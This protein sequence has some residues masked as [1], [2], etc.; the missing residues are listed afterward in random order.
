MFTKLSS[1][2]LRSRGWTVE[3]S[4]SK[5]L[6]KKLYVVV[7]HTH[8]KDFFLGLLL[9]SSENF[10]AGF[11][12]KKALFRFP[13]GGI[14]RALGGIPIDRSK[15]RQFIDQVIEKINESERITLTIAPE[16]TRKRVSKLKSGFYFIAK[17]ANIPYVLIKFDVKNKKFVFSEPMYATNDKTI[18]MKR[19]TDFFSG[20]VG[21]V[22]ENSFF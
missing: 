14:M 12:G 9:R 15:G 11:I 8:W 10:E 7:P 16:G 1:L 18:D 21:F 6:A 22:E 20:T 17:G 19:V 5:K 2:I 13:L 4:T 3:G